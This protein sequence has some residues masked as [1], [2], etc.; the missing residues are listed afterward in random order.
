MTL[1]ILDYEN[2][3]LKGERITIR[4]PDKD[5]RWI[6][7]FIDEGEFDSRSE[8]FRVA[9]RELIDRTLAQQQ[10]RLGETY[11]PVSDD[12]INALDYLI[13][14]GR[15]QSR[16]AAVFEILRNYLD[17]VDW[18]KLE[19]SEEKFREIKYKLSEAELLKKEIEDTYL[20]H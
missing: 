5:L 14:K 19:A 12:H 20:K 17:D 9:A 2:M 6:D 7:S 11:V 1:V 8:L 13:K 18:D 16:E 10:G 15:F 3:G 4:L